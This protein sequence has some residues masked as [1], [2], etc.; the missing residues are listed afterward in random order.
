MKNLCLPVMAAMLLAWSPL[1]TLAQPAATREAPVASAPR[2]S[3]PAPRPLTAAEQRESATIKG[4]L[5]PEGP[6]TTQLSIPLGKGADKPSSPTAKRGKS[7]GTAGG[8]DD[9]VAR[10]N[11]EV[12]ENERAKCRD[13][14]AHQSPKR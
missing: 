2:V 8:I 14:L 1:R 13:R 12:D 10:C 7:N 3:K 11:A 5:R 6:P 9:S 4:E